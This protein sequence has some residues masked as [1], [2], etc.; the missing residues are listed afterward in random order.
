VPEAT[1]PASPTTFVATCDL[2][3]VVRGRSVPRSAA[4]SVRSKGVGW[5]PADLALTAFGPIA[6]NRYGSVGDLRLLPVTEPVTVPGDDQR[7]AVDLVIAEQVQTD[8]S[9]WAGCPRSFARR[10][11]QDLADATGLRMIASFEHEFMLRDLPATAPF[12]WNRQRRA[13][14]FGTELVELLEGAGLEPETWLPEYGDGQYEITLTPTDALVAADRAL[15]LRELVRDLAERRGHDA[16]FAP[17]VDP[18]GSGNGVHLHFSLVDADGNAALHDPAAPSGL[19]EIGLRFAAGV[20]AHAPAILAISAPSPVSHLRLGPDR[21][22][23][24]GPFLAERNREAMLRICPTSTVGGGDPARQYNLEFRATDATANPWLVLGM[25]ARAGL[26]GILDELAA[27]AILPEE[28]GPEQLAGTPV[29]ATTLEESLRDLE[30]DP[31]ASAWLD[32]DLLDTFLNV[33]RAEIAAVADLTESERC[34][35]V[36]DVY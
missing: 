8:G 33:K 28:V 36:A 34:T 11:L 12:S 3:A 27:P 14:P 25:I 7:P 23:A 5:V 16:T 35:K 15:L 10:A 31:L 30:A 32:V 4:A 6:P 19:S 18:S 9:P 20:I 2:A 26:R 17:I 21:W 24:R 13:E 29:F 22:S 1:T